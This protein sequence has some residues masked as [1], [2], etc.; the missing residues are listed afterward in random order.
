MSTLTIR[1]LPKV[2]KQRLRLRAAANGKSMEA[3][4]RDILS[5]VLD[6]EHR[7]D[8]SW[9]GQLYNHALQEGGVNLEIPLDTP[10]FTD[11][12]LKIINPWDS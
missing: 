2:T 5:T 8:N 7:F 3:E 11:L 9:V 10:D 6:T 12:G 1:K 4:A